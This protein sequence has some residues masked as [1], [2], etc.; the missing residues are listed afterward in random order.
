M[1][2]L[3]HGLTNCLPIAAIF[4]NFK[5]A[6]RGLTMLKSLSVEV[7]PGAK[8]VLVRKLSDADLQALSTRNWARFIIEDR[9][10][11]ATEL[12]KL[13]AYFEAAQFPLEVTYTSGYRWVSD[14]DGYKTKILKFEFFVKIAAGFKT[15]NL[16]KVAQDLALP[17][18]EG[19]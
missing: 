6:F 12:D 11:V 15:V 4:G 16:E 18:V 3:D 8:P 13:M 5:K 7:T 1:K 10:T 9:D 17:L 2:P 14:E 19:R